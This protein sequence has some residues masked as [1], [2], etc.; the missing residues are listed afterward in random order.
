MDIVY[1]NKVLT[2][3]YILINEL[4]SFAHLHKELEVV[5]VR[6]GKSVAYADKNSYL[7][8][9]GDMFITFPN[10][11][12]YYRT[13]QKG[14]YIVLIFSPDIIY[15]YS[16]EI[17]KSVP[18]KNYFSSLDAGEIEELF[19]KIYAA[20]GEYKNL[21]ISGYINVIMSLVLPR[22]TLKTVNAENNSAFYNVIDFCT[23]NFTDDITL[24]L[25]AEKLHLSKYY[26]SHLINKRLKQNFN[27]YINNLRIAEACNL[28]RETDAKIADISEDVG[29]GTIRS[30]NRAFKL[31]MGISPAEYRSN[32]NALKKST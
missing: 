18:D 26:I 23:H 17:S 12:H 25:V 16:S 3:E 20:D 4:S 10:Q 31:I 24:D 32:S 2:M 9:A 28:L 19:D 1:E 29:F 27:E 5:Y 22:L 13:V 14:E 6:S 11:V 8:N 21:N 15:G 7:L 30:F